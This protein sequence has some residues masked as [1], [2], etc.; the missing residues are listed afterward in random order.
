M[1][2]K[3]KAKK[4]IKRMRKVRKHLAIEGGGYAI[5]VEAFKTMEKISGQLEDFVPLPFAGAIAA[6]MAIPEHFMRCREQDDFA[7]L[8]IDYWKCHDLI[9]ASLMTIKRPPEPPPCERKNW[10]TRLFERR[11]DA[12]SQASIRR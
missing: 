9:A 2:L 8:T 11:R 5:R 4:A 3:K 6:W 10:F 1:V 7:W 12:L